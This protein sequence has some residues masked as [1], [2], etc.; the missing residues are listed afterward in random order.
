MENS[1][2]DESRSDGA[3][4]GSY[5]IDTVTYNIFSFVKTQI[6]IS[7]VQRKRT[8]ERSSDNLVIDYSLQKIDDN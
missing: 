6:D 3:D 5:S 2:G 4:R 7:V 1:V 8:N